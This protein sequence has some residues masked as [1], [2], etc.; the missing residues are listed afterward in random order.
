MATTMLS[1]VVAREVD[2]EVAKRHRAS[3][4]GRER[5]SQLV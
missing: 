3:H 5:R 2:A 4:H 1:L